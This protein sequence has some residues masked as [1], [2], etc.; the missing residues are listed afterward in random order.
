[1]GIG[2]GSGK[3]RAQ[4]AAIEAISSPLLNSP[5]AK[6]KGVIFNVVGGKDVKLEEVSVVISSNS[7]YVA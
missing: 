4:D 3:N 7:G 2:K 1:M 6:A 5:I